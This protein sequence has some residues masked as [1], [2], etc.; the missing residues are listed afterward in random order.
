MAR[1]TITGN[2]LYAIDHSNL[3]TINI[4]NPES[5]TQAPLKQ[6][7]WGIETIFPYQGNLF[8]GAQNGMHIYSIA[9]PQSPEKL[10]TFS[11]VQSCDPVVVNDTLA[12]V[13]LRGGTPC[14]G[15][16]NQLDIINIKNL[17]SPQLLVSHSMTEPYGLGYD[18]GLLFICEGS[19]GLK[20]FDVTNIYDMSKRLLDQVTDVH[21]YDVIPYQDVLMLVGLDGLYQYDYSD[22]ADLKLISR[23]PIV[24]NN[25]SN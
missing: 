2:F 4:Q 17:Q 10:S 19:H 14:G 3:Y 22:P 24:R 16:T 12:Y 15:F 23:L 9:N 7:G 1:F 5:P 11:H 13:T 25:P 8:I 6:V 18:K 21:A 20:V